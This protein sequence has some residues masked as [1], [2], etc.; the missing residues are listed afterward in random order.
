MSLIDFRKF[1]KL[2]VALLSVPALMYLE[3][4]ANEIGQQVILIAFIPAK[5]LAKSRKN[6][7]LVFIAFNRQVTKY[8]TFLG[9]L[10]YILVFVFRLIVVVTIGGAGWYQCISCVSN[11]VITNIPW[12]QNC[13]CRKKMS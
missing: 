8:S 11:T 13:Q 1:W 5:F 4:C 9:Q 6:S 7:S 3:K 10:W 12:K 2:L